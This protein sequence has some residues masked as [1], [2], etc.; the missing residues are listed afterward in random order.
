M[1]KVVL[2]SCLIAISLGVFQSQAKNH[3]VSLGAG[4]ANDVWFDLVN[5]E[6]SS[7]PSANWDLAFTNYSVGG[8]WINDHNGAKA[9]LVPDVSNLDFGLPIDTAGMVENWELLYNSEVNWIVGAFNMGNDGYASNGNFGFGNYMPTN[10]SVVGNKLFVVITANGAYQFSPDVIGF[11]STKFKIAN[12]DGSDEKEITITRSDFAGEFMIYY[13]F[14]SDNAFSREPKLNDWQLQF[15]KYIGLAAIPGGG[16]ATMPYSLSGVRINNRIRVARIEGVMADE[17]VAPDTSSEEYTRRINVIG[18]DWKR[19]N[20]QFRFD[21]PD[22]LSFFLH[23]DSYPNSLFHLKFTAFGGQAIGNMDF[24][25]TEQTL[26]VLESDNL[27]LGNV[28]I[29]PNII[30]SSENLNL[31]YFMNKYIENMN[32]KVIDM[33]G[34]TLYTKSFSGVDGEGNLPLNI[35]NLAQGMYF[36]QV[37]ADGAI[38]YSKFIV[39]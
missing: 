39:Q 28:A 7:A 31:T 12:L 37:I 13:K 22:D 14:G 20:A 38:S 30:S 24:T 17:A 32:V 3:S 4:L 34:N 8:I 27:V 9:Y 2:I 5:G 29:T 35:N 1:K 11:T 23:A 10:H 36:V 18:S 6:V 15:G 26:S 33:N 21:I 19:L 25:L 16:G